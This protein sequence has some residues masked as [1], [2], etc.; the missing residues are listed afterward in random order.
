LAVIGGGPFAVESAQALNRLG[1]EVTL[2]EALDRL[3]SRDEP[4]LA[5]RVAEVLQAEGVD[6]RLSTAVTGVRSESGGVVVETAE[7]DSR[8]SAVL[9]ASGRTANV[10]SLSLDRLGIAAGPDGISVDAR[11]RTIVSSIYAVGD[12]AAGRS[13]FTHSA[14]HDAVMA[15]R[16]MFLPGRGAAA[17]LVPWVTFS[18]PQLAHVGMTAAEARERFGERRVRVTRFDLSDTD[19]ARID[20]TPEGMVMVVTARGKVVGGHIL[21]PEAGEMI[22]ELALAVRFSMSIR[23]LGEI[24]HVYPTMSTGISQMV[25]EQVFRRIRRLRRVA[26]LSRLM[27]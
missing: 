14:A 20:S 24:V 9:L 18:D 13:L 6:I 10:E 7:G 23:E 22:Q 11:S 15:V 8:A 21:A 5:A 3:L 16:D 26:K 19:R 1:V 2:F 12:A 17:T 4:A 25:A 27:G